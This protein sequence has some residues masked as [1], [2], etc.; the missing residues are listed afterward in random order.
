MCTFK[1]IKICSVALSGI[2]TSQK[3]KTQ[4]ITE[5]ITK[6]STVKPCFGLIGWQKCARMS[7]YRFSQAQGLKCFDHR[8]CAAV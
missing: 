5:V 4:V 1:L 8:A 3:T 6:K 7:S 2:L